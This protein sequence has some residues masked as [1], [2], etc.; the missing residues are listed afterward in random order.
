[1]QPVAGSDFWPTMKAHPLTKRR[2]ICKWAE[3]GDVNHKSVIGGPSG[4]HCGETPRSVTDAIK[5]TFS[6]APFGHIEKAFRLA[7]STGVSIS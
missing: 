1:M 6:I 3:E 7:N 2:R 4:D 5:W